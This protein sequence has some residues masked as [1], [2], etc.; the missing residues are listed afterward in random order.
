MTD[1]PDFNGFH[2]PIENWCKLPFE[3]I[4]QL[5]RISTKAELCVI[6]YVLRHTW[7]YREYETPKPIT[8]DEFEN[9]RKKQDG[10]RIDAGIGMSVPSI[11][12]GLKSAEKHGFL[13]IHTDDEDKGRIE[14][15]YRLAMYD[16]ATTVKEIQG[17]R[18]LPP[19][20]NEGLGGKKL[21]PWHKETYPRTEKDTL[22]R[23]EEEETRAPESEIQTPTL[24]QPP[25]KV[26]RV[27]K[28]VDKPLLPPSSA[29]PPS[30]P[31]FTLPVYNGQE[32]YADGTS[33]VSAEGY[34][35][36]IDACNDIFHAYV[37]ALDG[38][39]RKPDTEPGMLWQK[40]QVHLKA[41]AK[42]RRTAEQVAGF[43]HYA[44]SKQYKDDFYIR[45]SAPIT[46]AAISTQIGSWLTE[47]KRQK[48]SV[49]P[50]TV[51]PTARKLSTEEIE[52][53]LLEKQRILSE[54]QEAS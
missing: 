43:I 2:E 52:A 26:L 13:Q 35:D 7:G 42:H 29:P 41:L 24:S 30:R 10:S 6:L 15:S 17:E 28:S 3:L 16:Y 53:R 47:A 51:V 45:S 8:M 20:K 49:Q 4:A 32:N 40:N 5:P 12:E 34:K 46:L 27:V 54:Q 25:S 19:E 9:G 38:M 23:K 11:R 22:E 36:F 18:N 33:I 1:L 39:G 48:Q 44:Y 21:T 50:V 31:R 37:E 14:K